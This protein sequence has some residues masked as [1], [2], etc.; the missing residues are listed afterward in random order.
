MLKCTF[1]DFKML[2]N[3]MKVINCTLNMYQEHWGIQVKE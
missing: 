2:R 1:R 3:D